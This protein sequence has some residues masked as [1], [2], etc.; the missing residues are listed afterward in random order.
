MSDLKGQ[1]RTALEAVAR[2]FS[3]TWEGGSDNADAYITSA[4][5]R[6]AVDI[7]TIKRRGTGQGDAKL[8]LRFDKVATRLMERLQATCG[9]TLPDGMTVLVTVTAPIRL[10]AKT[11]AVLEDK[12]RLLGRGSPGRDVKDT[13]HGNRVR[14][15]LLR[16]ESERAPKM[17]GF[18]HNPDTDPPLLF[19]LTCELLEISAEA[20]SRARRHAGDRLLV[21]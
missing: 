18:V 20:D 8:H 4:G 17:I 6:A 12:I 7:R 9:E 10:A 13:I 3:A 1:E 14:I 21:L 2:R 5:E 11:A 15:R 19:N 16:N